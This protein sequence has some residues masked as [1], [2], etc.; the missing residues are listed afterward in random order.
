MTTEL[1][2]TEFKNTLI[3]EKELQDIS[4][5]S[6]LFSLTRLSTKYSGDYFRTYKNNAQTDEDLRTRYGSSTNNFNLFIEA[7]SNS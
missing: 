1:K 2:N 4:S 6:I 5:A 7:N 3:R